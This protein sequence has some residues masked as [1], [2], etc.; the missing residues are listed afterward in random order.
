MSVSVLLAGGGTG[1][2]I[3]PLLAVAD[4]IRRLRSDS[5][6]LFVGTRRGL[7]GGIV[8]ANG[9]SI[10]FIDILPIRG[11]GLYGAL[12][13]AV[14]AIA[15]MPESTRLIQRVKPDVVLSV[16]GY[17][18]GPITLA[19]WASGI[20]TALLEPNSE[21][22]LSNLL[23]A[24]IVDRAY[25]A[26]EPIGAALQHDARVSSR[27]AP[28]LGVQSATLDRACRSASTLGIGRQPGRVV[29]ERNHA[30]CRRFG[31]DCRRNSPS[32]R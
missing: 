17:A 30:N 4:A 24:S 16:G 27:R 13:G 23:L 18:A 11:G 28:A 8:P 3:F 2:H 6:L 19:A 21:M 14:R 20:A 1:G 32:V 25:T 7:E 15:A 5:Q 12:R 9:Y 22:G 31:R 10:E 29:A 26:F